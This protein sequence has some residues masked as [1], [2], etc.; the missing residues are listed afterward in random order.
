[1]KERE[2]CV[3][4]NRSVLEAYMRVVESGC[5]EKCGA[6]FEDRARDKFGC[7]V[8]LWITETLCGKCGGWDKQ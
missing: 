6:K 4:E 8:D 3:M 1:M 2:I 7:C 5:C